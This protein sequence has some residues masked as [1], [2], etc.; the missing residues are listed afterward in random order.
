MR[1]SYITIL[2]CIS[3]IAVVFLHTNGCFW[4]F[5]YEPYWKT[6]N[7]IESLFY[8]AVPVF[9]MISGATLIDYRE[10]Y[11]TKEFFAKRIRKAFIPYLFWSFAL[12]F[13]IVFAKYKSFSS[14]TVSELFNIGLNGDS[15]D[16]F[17]PLFGIYLSMPIITAINKDL[18]DK[19]FIYSAV[20]AGILNISMPFICA[21]FGFEYKGMTLL[22][23]TGALFYVFVGVLLDKKELAKRTRLIIYAT[24]MVGLLAQII[25]TYFLSYLKGEIVETFKGYFNLPGALYAIA[26]FLFFKTVANNKQTL[27]LVEIVANCSLEIYFFNSILISSIRDVFGLD[28]YS[29]IFRLGMPF[30]I[31]PICICLTFVFRKIPLIKKLVP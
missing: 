27:K 31:I 20:I 29:L 8:F 12:Y 24:G 19:V 9:Y 23:G 5:S 6:A 25:G 11:D 10:R 18:R 3:A 7:V 22:A 30:I 26:V 2:K 16:F 17:I 28:R 1:K 15:L 21:L 14:V 13:F 4:F